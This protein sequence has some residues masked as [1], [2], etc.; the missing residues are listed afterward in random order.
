[1]KKCSVVFLYLIVAFVVAE[2][3]SSDLIE[4]VEAARSQIGRT[5]IYDPSYRALDYPNGDVP[6]DRGV[7]TDVIIRALRDAF[8]YD[9]QRQGGPK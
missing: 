7:C 2:T 9:C 1:M 4:F 8:N 5:I 6:M 3:A